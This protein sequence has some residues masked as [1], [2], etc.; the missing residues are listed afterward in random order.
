MLAEQYSDIV[1]LSGEVVFCAD[2]NDDCLRGT[3]WTLEDEAVDKVSESSFKIH[4]IELLDNFIE[5]RGQC[6]QYPKNQ[7][8]VFFGDGR[9]TIRWLPDGSVDL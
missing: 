3:A 9:L 7:G 1:K 8:V 6:N 4:L 2:D 5:Y